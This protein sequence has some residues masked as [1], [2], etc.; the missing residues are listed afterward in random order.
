MARSYT[1]RNTEYWTNRKNI[2][3]SSVPAPITIN[4]VPVEQRITSQPFPDIDYGSTE[5]KVSYADVSMNPSAVQPSSNSSVR[6]RQSNTQGVDSEAFANIR[7]MRLPWD[8]AGTGMINSKEAIELCAR[9]YTGI[10]VIRNA[11]EVST[12]FSNQPL[13]IKCKNKTVKRFFRAWFK[14]IQ[15]NKLTSEFFREYYRSGNVFLQRFDGK[16]S[17]ENFQYMQTSFGAAQNKIPIRYYILNPVNIFV[18]SGMTFPHVYVRLL[19]TYEIERLKRPI[20]PEDKQIFNQLPEF[21][22]NQIKKANNF[23]MGL[24]IPIDP[25][26]LRYAFYKKQSYEP[27]A[28][29]MV[30]PVLPLIE[31]KLALQKADKDLA[32][33]VEMAILLVTNGETA[34]KENGGNGINP[35]NIARLQSFLSNHAV[36]RVLVADYTTKAEWKIPDLSGLGPQKYEVVNR[37]IQEGLQSL[38]S[39]E[40]KFANAQI[41]AKIFIQRLEEGQKCFLNDFLMPEI[42]TICKIMGFRD[43]PTVGFQKIALQDETVMARIYAQLVQLGVITPKQ[44]VIALKTGVLP[45]SDEMDEGQQ[46]LKTQREDGLYM[47]PA[48]PQQGQDGGRPGGSTGIKQSTKNV[49]P[50][51]T[52]RGAEMGAKGLSIYKIA[53]NIKDSALLES[54]VIAALK[55]EYN[56]DENTSLTAPQLSVAQSVTDSIIAL[57]PKEKWFTSV[58][59]FIKKPKII[60]QDILDELAEISRDYNVNA[61][62]AAIIRGSFVGEKEVS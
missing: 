3:V 46:E 22:K 28:T 42:E 47:P 35:N 38:L 54:S 4:T 21:A 58:S 29:P 51:G 60:S 61:R 6:L 8:P 9:A 1:K 12:E 43:V 37:D 41:K 33:T 7:A 53:Q 45:D 62:D 17:E 49:S 20:T 52:S 39:G 5:I 32:R 57:T 48:P 44:N 36:S 24:Y 27:L 59:S 10:P 30:W 19:S 11:I 25:E 2:S 13:W 34:T 31:W 50:Q 16:F 40:D 23:P 56:I 15:L 26:R 14:A 18:Q 55:S